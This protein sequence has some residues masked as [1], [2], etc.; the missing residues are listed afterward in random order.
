[1]IEYDGVYYWPGVDRWLSYNGVIREIPNTMNANYFFDNLNY[2]Q[3]QKVF[4]YKVPRFGEI[5]WHYPRGSATECTHAIIYNVRE[6]S[7]YDTELPNG[8]RSDGVYAKVYNKPFMTGVLLGGTGYRLWQHETGV[9]DVVG[10]T[11]EP[12]PS[13]FETAEI[14]LLTGDQAEDSGLRVAEIEPDFVQTGNLTLTVKGRANARAAVIEDDPVTIT[15]QQI[16]PAGVDADNQIVRV[17][18][19]KRLLTFRIESNE[20]DGDY[21]VGQSLAHIDKADSRIT[22]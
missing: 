7:W 17:K 9:N 2:T 12:I 3:R 15:E 5:W 19:T 4:A 18:T 13:H 8:G 1:M 16:P 22:Q 20:V 6:Q 11:I 21:Q 10:S 14:S